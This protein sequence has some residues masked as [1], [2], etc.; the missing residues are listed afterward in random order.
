M[1]AQFQQ[2]RVL[3]ATFTDIY[4]FERRLFY[5]NW[6]RHEEPTG[7]ELI[8]QSAVGANYVICVIIISPGNSSL[9]ITKLPLLPCCIAVGMVQLTH[10]FKRN[11]CR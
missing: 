2:R 1:H 8:N 10:A 11:V 5:S 3:G 7:S 4:T 9:K 6:R